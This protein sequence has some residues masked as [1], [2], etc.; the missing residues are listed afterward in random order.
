MV[1]DRV[2]SKSMSA[3][4]SDI[5]L[6]FAIILAALLCQ[7]EEAQL[8]NLR[9][10]LAV[11]ALCAEADDGKYGQQMDYGDRGLNLHYGTRKLTEEP[12]YVSRG[13]RPAAKSE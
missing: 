3:F 12:H 7:T 4:V 13:L 8:E 11:D 6:Q 2:N 5:Y 1:V 10:W 9:E